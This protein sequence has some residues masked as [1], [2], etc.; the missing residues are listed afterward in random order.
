MKRF[1]KS[2]IVLYIF[3]ITSFIIG[4]YLNVN[5][6]IHSGYFFIII[7]S[8]SVGALILIAYDLSK[9]LSKGIKKIYFRF[10]S[11]TIMSSLLILFLGCLTLYLVLA[12]AMAFG[13]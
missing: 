12:L 1:V 9:K 7:V 6:F 2:I 3:L 4:N 8:F 10:L 11:V 13:E 5:F